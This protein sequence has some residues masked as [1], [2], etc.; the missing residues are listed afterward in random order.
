MAKKI[1][2][3]PRKIIVKD[4]Y[5]DIISVFNRKTPDEAIVEIEKIRQRYSDYS[6]LCNFDVRFVQDWGGVRIVV[7]RPETDEEFHRRMKRNQLARERRQQIKDQER[8]KILAKERAVYERLRKKF[9][10]EQ[11]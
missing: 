10:T 11:D 6:F 9:E 3:Q 1:S 8:A 5:I 7:S 2:T 4:D